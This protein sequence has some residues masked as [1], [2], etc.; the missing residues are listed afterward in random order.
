[1]QTDD[2]R[3]DELIHLNNTFKHEL[4]IIDDKIHHILSA[5]SDLYED[6]GGDTNARLDSLISVLEKQVNLLTKL[7][8]EYDQNEQKYQHEINELKKYVKV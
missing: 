3:Y 8:S 6:I 5:R 4:Q 2:D 7:R 1:M